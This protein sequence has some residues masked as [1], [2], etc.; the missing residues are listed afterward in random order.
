M[1]P[2][3]KRTDLQKI[4]FLEDTLNKNHVV[5]CTY[6]ISRLYVIYVKFLRGRFEKISI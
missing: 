3:K 2:K 4:Q 1:N 5:T 6:I